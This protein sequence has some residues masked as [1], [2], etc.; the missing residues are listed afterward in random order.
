M[1]REE[2]HKGHT[3]VAEAHPR[4]KKGYTW[5]YQIDG[6]EMRECRDRPLRS[7]SV[8]LSEAVFEAK[9][10]IDRMKSGAPLT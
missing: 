5:S 4:G 1:R 10:A 8:A 9:A 3:I 7:E 2:Q 6:G